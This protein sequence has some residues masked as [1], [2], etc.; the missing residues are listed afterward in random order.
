[1]LSGVLHAAADLTREQ[2]REAAQRELSR[3]QYAEAEP[4]LIGRLVGRVLEFL[5]RELLVQGLRFGPLA[6]VLLVLLFAGLATVVLV[7]LGPVRRRD[8][9]APAV[10]GAE[11]P[12][13][14]EEHRGAAEAAAGQ[15]RFADAVRERLRAVVR[16]LEARGVLD[17]RPGRTA[18]EVAHDA[19][20]AVPA[21]AG[22][23]REA[24]G[25]FDAVW[26][27]GRPADRAA[28]DVLVRL[29]GR[30]R[31]TRTVSP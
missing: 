21:L 30:V 28:Y 16:E 25:V 12:R 8:G 19:G 6:Q 27:G 9:L 23:L 20:A 3:S 4:S 1:M 22:H 10:F 5:S 7:R 31:E 26:Y 14:A 24:A 2:A 18:G 15:G 17:V 13:T 11:R 29:D